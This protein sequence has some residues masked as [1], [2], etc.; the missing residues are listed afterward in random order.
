LAAIK[1]VSGSF[2]HWILKR[3]TF[4]EKVRPKISEEAEIEAPGGTSGGYLLIT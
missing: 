3:R 2:F 1:K 4:R